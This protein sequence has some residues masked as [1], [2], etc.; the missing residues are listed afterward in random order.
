MSLLA[1]K[2]LRLRSRWQVNGP[3]Y[4]STARG[5]GQ[6]FPISVKSPCPTRTQKIRQ[7]EIKAF[8]KQAKKKKIFGIGQQIRRVMLMELFCW[9]VTLENYK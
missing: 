4:N 9:P 7:E 3:R 5:L 8:L 6:I 1:R 2:I